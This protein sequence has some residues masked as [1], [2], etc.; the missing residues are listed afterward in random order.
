[1]CAKRMC[2][3]LVISTMGDWAAEGAL[4][5]WHLGHRNGIVVYGWTE[6][7]ACAG[8]AVAIRP[9][10][11]CFQ[12]GFTHD[13]LPLL[14]VTEWP[15]GESIRQEPACGAVYQPYGPVELGHVVSVI[16]ELAIDC[17]LGHVQYATHRVWAARRPLLESIGGAW[18]PE[19]EAIAGARSGGGFVEE[20]E[21]P[22]SSSCI[23]CKAGAA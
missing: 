12:C 17:L 16:A 7:H 8:H 9:D 19:W 5:E 10:W 15:Q 11:G 4:N 22:R 1:L 21:W 14:R 6:A 18:T 13:G 3:A 20:R 2:S 23:E